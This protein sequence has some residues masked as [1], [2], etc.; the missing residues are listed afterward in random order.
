VLKV[1]K[2]FVEIIGVVVVG[3]VCVIAIMVELFSNGA[4]YE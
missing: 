2:M 1:L 4:D 3:V